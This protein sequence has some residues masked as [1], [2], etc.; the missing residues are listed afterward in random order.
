MFIKK[1]VLKFFSHEIEIVN[2][3]HI[4][5]D[6]MIILTEGQVKLNKIYLIQVCLQIH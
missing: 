2:K 3:F 4:Y 5:S 1:L 6:R